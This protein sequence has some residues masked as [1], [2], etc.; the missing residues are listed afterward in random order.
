MI[1]EAK[2]IVQ[3]V[4][5]QRVPGI[6]IV[7]GMR[8]EE[9]AL[10]AR[11]LPLVSLITNPGRFDDRESKT[12][13]YPDAEAGMWKER[14]VRGRRIVPVLLRC[15]AEG[16]DAADALFSRILP[17]I[18][19]KWELDEFEGLIVIEREEHADFGD[20]TN[21]FYLS[22]ADIEFSIPVALEATAVPTIKT[23]EAEPEMTKA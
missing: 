2:D 7:R 18:P 9:H 11:K 22:V 17:A 10:M 19:R 1:K 12:I 13:R 16:E 5:S 4:V 15:F 8:E 3:A 23:V 20:S 6:T 21:K 14:Y